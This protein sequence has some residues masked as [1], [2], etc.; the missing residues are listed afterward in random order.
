MMGFNLTPWRSERDRRRKRQFY[1]SL[2]S[3]GFVVLAVEAVIWWLLVLAHTQDRARLV[4]L[5]EELSVVEQ[6]MLQ[7]QKVN[8]RDASV[9]AT[10]RPEHQAMLKY[11]DLT[12]SPV[13]L[14]MDLLQHRPNGLWI[15]TIGIKREGL[16]EAGNAELVE[17]TMWMRAWA[18]TPDEVSRFQS[19]WNQ[20]T[21]A[22]VVIKSLKLDKNG[23][24]DVLI[25]IKS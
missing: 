3:L 15:R 16:H 11:W 6:D 1:L 17:A 22:P 19:S 7:T 18:T 23:L 12:Q 21:H 4:N 8:E 25:E 9:L 2:L 13:P 14:L 20:T 5:E 24:Y 10:I